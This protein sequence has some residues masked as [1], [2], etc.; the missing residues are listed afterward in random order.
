[1]CIRDSLSSPESV[2]ILA[3]RF[4]GD[5]PS[6]RSVPTDWEPTAT[7]PVLRRRAELLRNVRTFFDARGVMEVQ[8]PVL[9]RAPS[10]DANVASL[11]TEVDAPRPVTAYL[12]TSPEHSMKRLL[13]SGS[14]SIYQIGPVFRDAESGPRHNPEF[15]M[16]EWY[17]VGFDHHALMDLSLIHISEPTR[18]C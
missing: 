6:M 14:G 11:T 17:R 15:T 7:L 13:A 5:V 1:M 12:R 18:P 2:G 10:A 8:T 16:L 3:G 9:L 4:R